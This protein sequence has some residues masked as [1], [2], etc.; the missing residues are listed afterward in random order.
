MQGVKFSLSG[1]M[2]ALVAGVVVVVFS[3]FCLMLAAASAV[4]TEERSARLAAES[5]SAGAAE[6]EPTGAVPT[7]AA[8][9]AARSTP[10]PT[11]APTIAAPTATPKPSPTTNQV[12]TRVPPTDAPER[13]PEEQRLQYIAD[14]APS[15]ELFTDGLGT[16]GAALA[17]PNLQSSAW[18]SAVALGAASV[19]VAYD[20]LRKVNPPPYFEEIHYQLV[21]AWSHCDASAVLLVRSLDEYNGG[22]TN[23][24]QRSMIQAN[25]EID[26]CTQKIDETTRALQR[27]MP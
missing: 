1:R 3:C 5:S 17:M 4:L 22:Q 6:T 25:R 16:L 21:D 26:T 19:S 8:Q 23:T 15:F 12:P 14:T 7:R 27:I 11:A 20:D 9:Q 13:T 2:L 18:Q 24:A 10:A